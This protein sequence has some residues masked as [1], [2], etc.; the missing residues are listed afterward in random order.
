M[1]HYI[2]LVIHMI[3]TITSTDPEEFDKL[4]NTFE[5]T[6]TYKTGVSRV[7]ATQTHVNMLEG[8][9]TVFTA[10]IFYR[11]VPNE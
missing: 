2:I 6:T 8:H 10:I 1:Y 11:E 9:K 4:V 5:T 3:K 7:F